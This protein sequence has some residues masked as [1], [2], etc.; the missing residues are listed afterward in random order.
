ML[1]MKTRKIFFGIIIGTLLLTFMLTFISVPINLAGWFLPYEV[2]TPSYFPF[3]IKESYAKIHYGF[4][5]R[6]LVEFYYKNNEEEMK[7]LV[8]NHRGWTKVPH[9]DEKENIEDIN[10]YYTE[11]NH[12]QLLSWQDDNLEYT[13]EYRNPKEKLPKDELIKVFQSIRKNNIHL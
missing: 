4:S 9:W 6:I 2:K 11:F 10:T 8:T 7:L 12:I 5:N 13:I 1:S 3:E